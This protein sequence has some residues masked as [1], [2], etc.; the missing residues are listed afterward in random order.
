MRPLKYMHGA[1][2][3]TYR[4]HFE[5]EMRMLDCDEHGEDSSRL[6]GVAKYCRRPLFVEELGGAE[7][8]C[9]FRTSTRQPRMNRLSNA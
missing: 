1:I 5:K 6:R 4:C 9:H 7:D 8:R 2:R 3:H